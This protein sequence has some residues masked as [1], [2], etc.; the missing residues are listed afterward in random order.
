[1]GCVENPATMYFRRNKCKQIPSSPAMRTVSFSP[2]SRYTGLSSSIHLVNRP[3][4]PPQLATQQAKQGQRTIYIALA[5]LG[6]DVDRD[7]KGRKTTKP[8]LTD[9]AIKK[10]SKTSV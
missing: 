9:T 8:A 5:D 7:S 6:T 3:F 10:T 1:M 2:D 4:S